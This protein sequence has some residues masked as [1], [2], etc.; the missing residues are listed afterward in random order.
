MEF[1][2]NSKPSTDKVNV[3]PALRGGKRSRNDLTYNF[4][5]YG[6]NVKMTRIMEFFKSFI[7]NNSKIKESTLD[8]KLTALPKADYGNDYDAVIISASPV[9]ETDNGNVTVNMAIPIVL[10]DNYN[11]LTPRKV[12]QDLQLFFDKKS[13]TYVSNARNNIE[14][15]GF[16][17]P[18]DVLEETFAASMAVALGLDDVADMKSLDGI[19][20]QEHVNLEEDSIAQAFAIRCIDPILDYWYKNILGE[21]FNIKDMCEGSDISTQFF[22]HVTGNKDALGVELDDNFTLQVVLHTK[23]RNKSIT[24]NQRGVN[25]LLLEARGAVCLTPGAGVE[26]IDGRETTVP[27]LVPS[28]VLKD[29]KTNYLLED[30]LTTIASLF[31]LTDRYWKDILIETATETRDPG[32]MLELI[33]EKPRPFIKKGVSREAK[34]EVIRKYCTAGCA[35][36]ID[37]NE[38]SLMSGAFSVIQAAAKGNKKALEEIVHIASL[39]CVKNDAGDSTF[40]PNFPINN[41]FTS[42]ELPGGYFVNTDGAKR[43]LGSVDGD[44]IQSTHPKYAYAYVDA[45]MSRDGLVDMIAIYNDIGLA[46]ARLTGVRRRVTFTADFLSELSNALSA[47]GYVLNMESPITGDER[48]RR[49]GYSLDDTRRFVSSSNAASSMVRHSGGTDRRGGRRTASNSTFIK[50]RI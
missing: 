23:G 15:E 16:Y 50:R 19:I 47:N 10:E 35:V 40:D 9:V 37:I 27:K 36:S 28:I 11:T 29:V 49:G 41:I 39:M 3:K 14:Q 30:A 4:G 7:E 34:E 20:V 46:S 22:K 43:S 45:E 48:E 44:Y 5:N 12:V 6:S 32:N 13:G 24:P 31:V 1:G 26:T 38:Y 33:G 2:K 42:T 18:S 17:L 8:F 25:S 21:V